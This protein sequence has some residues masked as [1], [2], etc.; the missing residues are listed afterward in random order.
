VSDSVNFQMVAIRAD[1]VADAYEGVGHRANRLQ[2]AFEEVM[3]LLE[4]D[5][6]K[7]FEKMRGRY[8]LTGATRESLT[9]RDARGAIRS[10]HAG[11]L[12]FGTRVVQAH[13]LTKSPRDPENQQISKHNGHGRSAVLVFKKGTKR[14]ASQLILRHIVGDFGR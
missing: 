8:V 3:G 6:R 2:P 12:A 10:I 11:G 5:E 9:Q 1:E 13:Y 14:K 4:K 7:H